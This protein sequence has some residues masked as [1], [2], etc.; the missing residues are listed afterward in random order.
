L[1]QAV[2]V[3]L[4]LLMAQ[5]GDKQ[6]LVQFWMPVAAAAGLFQL[7]QVGHSVVKEPT[8]LGPLTILLLVLLAVVV[9]TQ[10][11]DLVGVQVAV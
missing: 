1:D 6:V 3:V 11:Q 2:Q 7:E 8:L 4:E 5:L 10:V 9:P